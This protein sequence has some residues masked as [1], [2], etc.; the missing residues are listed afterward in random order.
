MGRLAVKMA[1]RYVVG[2]ASYQAFEEKFSEQIRV[3]PHLFLQSNLESMI[4]EDGNDYT[5]E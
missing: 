5:L 4:R 3:N 2:I 1:Y